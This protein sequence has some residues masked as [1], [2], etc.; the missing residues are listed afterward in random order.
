MHIYIRSMYTAALSRAR[1]LGW[2]GFF[3]GGER[4]RQTVDAAFVALM[5]HEWDRHWANCKF[6]VFFPIFLPPL[7]LP[8]LSASSR[9]DTSDGRAAALQTEPARS[10]EVPGAGDRR[11]RRRR[12]RSG[13]RQQPAAAWRPQR[14]RVGKTTR[15]CPQNHD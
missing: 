5:T 11:R 13:R 7:I 15:S 14:A 8:H 12:R 2:A 3:G 4:E 9:P 6:Q 1:L 10:R